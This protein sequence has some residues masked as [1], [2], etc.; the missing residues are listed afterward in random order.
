MKQLLITL[1]V[2]CISIGGRAPKALCAVVEPAKGGEVVAI[3]SA[4]PALADPSA[5]RSKPD[6]SIH[7]K[8]PSIVPEHSAA[9][10]TSPS[11][12]PVGDHDYD[13]AIGPTLNLLFRFALVLVIAYLASVLVRRFYTGRLHRSSGG[14]QILETV[15]MG[16]QRALHVVAVGER[17]LLLA[18]ATQI[19]LIADV[20]QDYPVEAIREESQKAPPWSAV[21]RKVQDTISRASLDRR[22]T[23]DLPQT[24]LPASAPL[25]P[26]SKS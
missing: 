15:P 1:V 13:T 19:S 18:S 26:T 14:I 5:S 10:Q 17:R 12:S 9:D 16:Q 7:P 8:D 20:T 6:A 2:I 23:S 22:A 11:S 25:R 4:S 21:A 3:A 24:E